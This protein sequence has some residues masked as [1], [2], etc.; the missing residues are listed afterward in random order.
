[1]QLYL[2]LELVRTTFAD[3]RLGSLLSASCCNICISYFIQANSV[4]LLGSKHL[5]EPDLNLACLIA[6]ALPDP[7]SDDI[8]F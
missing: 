4:Y 1:M 3:L 7:V 6:I 8:P 2:C 5:A